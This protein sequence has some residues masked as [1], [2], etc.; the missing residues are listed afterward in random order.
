MMGVL[1]MKTCNKQKYDKKSAIT[2]LN[3]CKKHKNKQY[4]KECRYYYCEDCG[5]YHLTSRE[6]YE[7]PV[8]LEL[9][10][11][12]FKDLWVKLKSL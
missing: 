11:L 9:K 12:I 3:Y 7:E 8:K 1:V 2:A 10:D 4:K 5:F 6:E